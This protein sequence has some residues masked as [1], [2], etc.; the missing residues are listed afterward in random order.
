MVFGVCV[1]N[2][3]LK[4]WGLE[5]RVQGVGFRVQGLGLGIRVQGLGFRVPSPTL[6]PKKFD[7]AQDDVIRKCVFMRVGGGGV[8][9]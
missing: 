7:V 2:S 9:S 5:L 8:G 4:V 3:Q 1:G 6:P